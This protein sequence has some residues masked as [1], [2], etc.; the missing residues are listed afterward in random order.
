MKLHYGRLLSCILGVELIG[1]IGSL[2][3]FS[4]ITTWYAALEKPAFNPPNGIFGPVWTILFGLMGISL[5]LVW[6][7]GANKKQI[8]Q[9]L[10]MFGIQ[11]ALNVL[12]SF[13][14][15]GWHQPGWAF[16]EIIILWLAILATLFL[17]YKISKTAAW[18]LVPYLAWVTFASVLTFA[19]WR[20][21]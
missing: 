21:N 13:V 3:T 12:W 18:L 5:Y 7:S 4:Q 15:F 17:F 9:V 8:S 19:V 10:I 2:A 6:S 14:F 11:L 20:L 16:L 1:N